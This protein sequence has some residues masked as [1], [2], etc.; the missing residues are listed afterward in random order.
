MPKNKT[1]QKSADKEQLLNGKGHIELLRQEQEM[2]QVVSERGR[3]TSKWEALPLICSCHLP[4]FC[5]AFLNPRGGLLR[6]T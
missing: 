6:Y 2:A 5:K 3:Q 4:L 1:K